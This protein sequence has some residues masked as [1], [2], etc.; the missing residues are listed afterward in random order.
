[1]R[2]TYIHY[3]Y[4]RF[5]GTRDRTRHFTDA[6][7]ALGHEIEVFG[8]NLVPPPPADRPAGTQPPFSERLRTTLRR[9]LGRYLHE[10]K[11]IYWNLRYRPLETEVIE[12]TRPE[13]VIVRPSGL[14]ISVIGAAKQLDVPLI[15]EIHAP[16]AERDHMARYL[17][18]PWISRWMEVHRLRRADAV[19]T[20]STSLS[21]YFVG[22][23]GLPREKFVVVPNGVE[24]D[25]FHPQVEPDAEVR[26]RLGEGPVVGFVGSFQE[27]HGTGLLV[28]MIEKVAATHPQARFLLVGEGHTAAEVRAAVAPL[29]EKV[30]FLGW[31]PHERMAGIVAAIDVGVL[32]EADFY[33][34]PLKL[35]EWMAAGC[36]V[37]VPRYAPLSELVEEG[38]EG[39][40]FAPRDEAGFV[41][42]VSRLIDDPELCQKL[43]AAASHRAHTTMSWR[44]SAERAASA[45]ELAIARHREHRR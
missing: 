26:Q 28:R 23:Y 13:V 43:G 30:L 1:M 18:V 7:R 38:E 11:E 40:F 29:G 41:A 25:R 15:F 34:C 24:L 6:V 17:H 14:G 12:R 27:W 42:A 44:A 2:I 4:G 45:C 31:T 22:L 10:P 20:V 3:L 39:L 35:V 32:P 33:R 21:E 16:R 37:V 19:T 8:L 9:H 5:D 36:G